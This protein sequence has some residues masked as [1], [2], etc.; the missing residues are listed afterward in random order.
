MK[1]TEKQKE[2]FKQHYQKNKEKLLLLAKENYINNKEQRR[3]IRDEYVKKNPDK[4]ILAQKNWYIKNKEI[5]LKKTKEYIKNNLL[6][7]R[8]YN[9]K[10]REREN[11]TCNKSINKDSIIKM[12]SNQKNNCVF[13]SKDISINYHIDHIIPLTKKGFH[14]IENIQLLC[15]TCNLSKN[16]KTNE[17][18][19]KFR[20]LILKV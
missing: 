20:K 3:K 8:L 14:I 5:K 18:F 4:I 2:L 9:E 10:R 6:K 19:I 1:A 17:E 15:P 16:K 13:C 11:K 7:H 12:M